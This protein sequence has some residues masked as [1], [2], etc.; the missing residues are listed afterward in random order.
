MGERR[1]P[2]EEEGTDEL[3]LSMADVELVEPPRPRDAGGGDVALGADAR[4]LIEACERELSRKPPPEP[5]RAARLH[6]EIARLYEGVLAEPARAATHYADALRLSPDHVPSVRGARR[7]TLAAGEP[8]QAVPLFDAE[9]RATADPR[10]RARLLHEKGRLLEESLGMGDRAREA[11]LAALEL[12]PDDASILK[13]LERAERQRESWRNLVTTYERLGNAVASD[14]AHRAALTAERGRLVESR[15]GDPKNAALLYRAALETDP[16][17]AGVLPSLVRLAREQKLSNELVHAFERSHA[18]SGSPR[19]RA[20]ALFSLARVARRELGDAEAAIRALSGALELVPE[21]REMRRELAAL[22]RETGRAAELAAALTV[23]AKSP[24]SPAEHV[25]L[26]MELGRIAEDALGDEALARRWYE[27]A[28]ATEPSHAP[29]L[30]ALTALLERA[31]DFGALVATLS[32]EAAATEDPE[33]RADLHARIGAICEERLGRPDDAEPHHRTAL[34]LFPDHEVS[35]RALGRLYAQGGKHRELVELY[36]RR[37]DRAPD[38]PH[39]VAWLLRIGAVYEDHLDDPRGALHAYRRVLERDGGH[40]GAILGV[41]RAAERGGVW[42]ELVR[43]LELEADRSAPAR[44]TALRVRAARV[45]DAHLDDP[46]GAIARLREVVERDPSH[47]PA[48]RALSELY[49]RAGRWDDL[50]GSAERLIGALPREQHVPVLYRVGEL[51]RSRMGREAAAAEWFRRALDVDPCHEPS[52]RALAETLVASEDWRALAK[53]WEE[54]L[55]GLDDADEG[56]HLALDLGELYE[57][58]LSD[59]DRALATYER[60]LE[61]DPGFRPALDARA[62]LLES[63]SAW[64][65]LAEALHAEAKAATDV[66][67]ALDARMRE[68]DVLAHRICDLRVAIGCFEEILELRPGNARALLALEELY[69]RAHDREGLLRV[70]ERQA[71]GFADEGARAASLREL[72]RLGEGARAKAAWRALLEIEREDHEALEALA[73]IAREGDDRDASVELEARMAGAFGKAAAVAG[74]H[75][76]RVAELLEASG[77][78][79]ALG[80]YRAALALDSQSL[81]ATRGFTRVARRSGDPGAIRQAARS[82]AKASRDVDLAVELFLR[83]AELR[84]QRNELGEAAADLTEA[85]ELAPSHPDA[86][87]ELERVM[88]L[89]DRVPELVEILSRAA[90]RAKPPERAASLHVQVAHLWADRQADLPA[91]IAAVERAL[92]VAP[93]HLSA[94][95]ILA[96][97][98]ERAGHWKEAASALMSFALRSSEPRHLLE[99]H[100]RLAV[101]ADERLRDPMRARKS[102]EEVLAQEPAHRVALGRLSRIHQRDG[103]HDEALALARRL[104]EASNDDRERAEALVEVG[105]IERARGR[106][107][108]AAAALLE[109]LEVQGPQGPAGEAYRSLLAEHPEHGTWAAYSEVLSK[110]R[111]RAERTGAP[112]APVYLELA[113]ALAD[114]LGQP[115]RALDVLREAVGKLPGDVRASVA[116]A[117]R[118]RLSGAHDQALSELERA[119][120]TDVR[121]ADVWREMSET[122]RAAGDPAEAL[123]ALVPLRALDAVSP[124]ELLTLRGLPVRAAQARPGLLGDAGFREVQVDG[125][126]D[127]SATALMAA[128]AEAAAKLYPADLARYGVSRRDRLTARSEHPLRTVADRVAEIL[129]VGDFDVHLHDSPGQEVRVELGS[130]PAL[131][132]PSWAQQLSHPQLVYLLAVPLAHVSRETHPLLRIPE[133]EV[134]LLLAAAARAAAP[135]FGGGVASETD[136]DARARALQKAVPRRDR[137]RLEEAAARYAASPPAN[138]A[139]WARAMRRT[140][141]RAALLVCDDLG[142]ALEVVARTSGES[143]GPDNLPS[144]LARF[145]VSNP[146]RRFRKAR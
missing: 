29:A 83:A 32:A 11:Y 30:S 45:L 88:V 76:T 28:L 91:A 43:A 79:D 113:R 13:A 19:D 101:I 74:H 36:E 107:A 129:G 54:R 94:L 14:P 70:Y 20:T 86:A 27:T 62:R 82:E 130:T 73:R 109:A 26:A 53:L 84:R 85:L 118:L 39:A 9:I 35:F 112:L 117:R 71:E 63:A 128:V 124:E 100:L 106:H 93:R 142:S 18:R 136:L 77:S 139:A 131:M 81:S 52:Y 105:R 60:A 37:V 65:R 47:L 137:R 12:A 33:R 59:P 127:S 138:V 50:V 41:Q 144:D 56:L 23:L 31:G 68:G 16:S 87:N 46:S 115:E 111:E 72:A 126:V 1:E 51:C 34:G 8:A 132:M 90:D 4:E 146:A 44:A 15:L 96:S 64:Q 89:A 110:H 10:T 116:L 55:G 5:A 3:D 17:S 25:T 143:L 61:V 38:D 123:L 102:L 98:H 92:E 42:D 69:H 40:V 97:Y 78:P 121:A 120:H 2:F 67:D 24:A 133:E 99:A 66:A 140:A 21:D 108:D 22:Y 58:R 7:T 104:T 119:M 95:S 103:R 6:Y 134:P 135:S 48:L 145:W 57:D 125:A 114:E 75:Q 49:E 122:L 141:A 80:A